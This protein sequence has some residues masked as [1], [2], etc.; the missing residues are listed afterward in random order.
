MKLSIKLWAIIFAMAPAGVVILIAL[1]LG[2]CATTDGVITHEVKVPV[3]VKCIKQ[4][5]A[6]P[7]YETPQLDKN[8]ADGAKIIALARD[9]A[10]SR[11]YEGELEAVIE[12]CR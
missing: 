6:K 10:R 2:G 12:G 1:L 3:H 5:P 9:W 4:T 11:K 7:E 8:A